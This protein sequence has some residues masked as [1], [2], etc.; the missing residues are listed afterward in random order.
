MLHSIVAYIV[1]LLHIKINKGHTKQKPDKSKTLNEGVFVRAALMDF[2][3]ASPILFAVKKMRRNDKHTPKKETTK[4]QHLESAHFRYQGAEC[5][6]AVRPDAIFF[7]GHMN[8][9]V[10]AQ[11]DEPQSHNIFRDVFPAFSK[12]ES[13]A[14]DMAL[15][16]VSPRLQPVAKMTL[17]RTA[18]ARPVKFSDS[19]FKRFGRLEHRTHM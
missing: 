6:R 13:K 8:D 9:D 19:R 1:I 14:E 5:G 12:K 11:S 4:I 15:T 7:G 10:D 2:N 18:I 16:P 17:R 3:P